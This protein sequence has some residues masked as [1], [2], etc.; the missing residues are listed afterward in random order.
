MF[1]MANEFIGAVLAGGVLVAGLFLTKPR[2]NTN[3]GARVTYVKSTTNEPAQTR[4]VLGG[5]IGWGLG[6]IGQGKSLAELPPVLNG[7][8]ARTPAST[9]A[10]G[11][12]ARLL[13]DLMR[14]FGLT[15]PQA[16]GIVGNLDHET[17]GFRF[18]QEIAPT[19]AG[20]RGG[21]GFAQWT[22]P[23]RREFEEWAAKR[24]LSV[25]SYAA[26]Y[27]FLKYE[28]TET[29]EKRAI[30]RVRATTSVNEAARVF[31]ATFLRP[32]VVNMTSRVERSQRYA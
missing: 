18:M 11:T 25:S 29:W 16:A 22:G 31:S 15:R 26:N 2:D 20:S 4:N 6:Q 7:N 12:G 14:D 21:Y 17:G 30:P 24:G 1:E 28:L 10:S 3:T 27:G 5:L 13:G 32:G 23:R 8:S 9:T 19:V